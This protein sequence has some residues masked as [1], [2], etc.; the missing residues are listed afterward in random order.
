MTDQ[1]FL[2]L[3]SILFVLD[4]LL[5]IWIIRHGGRELNPLIGNLIDTLGVD[6]AFLLVKVICLA[7][8]ALHV[9]RISQELRWAALILYVLVCAWNARVA[10]SIKKK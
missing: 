7:V 2:I 1:T 10:Y 6:G 4:A 8:I 3:L 9:A 5:T